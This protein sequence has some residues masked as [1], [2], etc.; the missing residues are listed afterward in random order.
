MSSLR[1]WDSIYKCLMG[2]G[3]GGRGRGADKVI[4]RYT[5]STLQTFVKHYESTVSP[6]F[7]EI[8]TLV[9]LEC[10]SIILPV[11]CYKSSCHF[12]YL[13]LT[14]TGIRS[15][16]SRVRILAWSYQSLWSYLPL[17]VEKRHRWYCSGH[18]VFS[19]LWNLQITWAGIKSHKCSKFGQSGLFTLALP[20]SIAEKTIFYSLCMLDSGERSLS[21]GRL[22]LKSGH[23]FAR[24]IP[25]GFHPC[26]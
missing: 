26:Q 25:W 18:I 5:G 23:I 2:G 6:F 14:R 15:R 12:L 24:D 3:G 10:Q 7:S 11:A 22:V 19:F 17:I 20:A 4:C 8:P 21:F 9:V 16:T 13:L 1:G